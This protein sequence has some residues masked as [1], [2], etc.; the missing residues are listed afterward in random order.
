M[1]LKSVKTF[2]ANFLN[3]QCYQCKQ[4]YKQSTDT[5]IIVLLLDLLLVQKKYKISATLIYL[6]IDYLIYAF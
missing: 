4:L 6:V 2:Q 5:T 1:V 3:Y